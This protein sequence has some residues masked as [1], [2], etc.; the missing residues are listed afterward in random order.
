MS[1]AHGEHLDML[2]EEHAEGA[3][4]SMQW[5]GMILFIASEALI[6][7]NFIAMYLYLEI[8]NYHVSAW[9][10][11]SDITYPIINTIILICSSFPAHYAGRG[12]AKGNQRQL[13]IGLTLTII[14]GAVFL[15]GQVFEY[16]GL[17][18]D[19]GFTPQKD[20]FGSAF[21]TLTGFHGLHVTI[22]V[23]FLLICLI[24]SLRGDFTVKNHFAVEAAEMY[25]H[26]VDIVWIIVFSLIYLTPLLIRG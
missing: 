16:S 24:R 7:A 4:R 12:I 15:G 25:W 23:I 10:L 5:W 6:F 13:K 19:F 8:R 1:V 3:G 17:F 2:H 18:G 11:P 21:F 22:G 26:F 20:I 14:M 9:H